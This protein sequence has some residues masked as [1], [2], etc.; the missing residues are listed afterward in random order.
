MTT[1][2]ERLAAHRRWLA[3]EPDGV[4]LVEHGADLRCADLSGADLPKPEKYR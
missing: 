1:L 4:R 3:G 2:P